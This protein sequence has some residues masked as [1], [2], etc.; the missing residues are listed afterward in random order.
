M[1]IYESEDFTLCDIG[2]Y[3]HYS[4]PPPE[5]NEVVTPRR[6]RSSEI[7]PEDYNETDE[8]GLPSYETAMKMDCTIVNRWFKQLCLWFAKQIKFVKY[9]M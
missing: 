2:R 5:Y 8:T 9:L 4:G 6:R 7:A 1:Q 3:D